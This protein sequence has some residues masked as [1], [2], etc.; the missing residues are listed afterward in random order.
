M[1]QQPTASTEPATLFDLWPLVIERRAAFLRAI[2]VTE[3]QARHHLGDRQEEWC[4]LQVAQ[5]VVG[6]TENVADVIEALAAGH[7]EPKHPRGY[8]PSAMPETLAEVR[9]RLVRASIRFTGLPE[10][11]PAYPNA[12]VTVPHEI[13]GELNYRGWFARCAAHDLDHA[14]QV[15]ALRREIFGAA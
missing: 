2:D 6:W 10:R 14:G 12:A 8:I 1:T 5:H 3:E 13:Y 11:M 15:E 9:E 7:T 4:I